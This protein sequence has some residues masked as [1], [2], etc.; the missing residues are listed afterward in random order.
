MAFQSQANVLSLSAKYQFLDE[1]PGLEDYYS[2]D[3]LNGFRESTRD[4]LS[5]SATPEEPPLLTRAPNSSTTTN[6]P[7]SRH[8]VSPTGTENALSNLAVLSPTDNIG[9]HNLHSPLKRNFT[10]DDQY[11]QPAKRRLEHPRPQYFD[12]IRPEVNGF[13]PKPIGS[14]TKT[15]RAPSPDP[16]NGSA[17]EAYAM[18]PAERVEAE[19]MRLADTKAAIIPPDELLEP[20]IWKE[21]FYWPNKYTTTQCACLLRYFIEVLGPWVSNSVRPN[22]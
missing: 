6:S 12:P 17:A 8:Q 3:D 4:S 19:Y 5:D 21:K 22:P 1:G 7:L 2:N 18:D 10:G 9:S 20:A 13:P 15:D 16:Y 14:S 11:H